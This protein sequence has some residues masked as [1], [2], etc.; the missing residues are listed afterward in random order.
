M[1]EDMETEL[2][3]IDHCVK[4]LDVLQ[5][6]ARQRALRYLR[7]RYP[8]KVEPQQPQWSTSGSSLG[9]IGQ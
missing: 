1:A 8:A 2:L 6:E 7:D 5:D 3:A 9:R 4:A